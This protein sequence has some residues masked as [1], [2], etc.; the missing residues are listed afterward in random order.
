M[1]PEDLDLLN[2]LHELRAFKKTYEASALNR[3]FVRL[4]QL[5]DSPFQCK[6][7]TIMSVRSFRILAEAILELKRALDEKKY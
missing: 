7:D 1:T 5:L 4:E 2:E 6:S 3:A